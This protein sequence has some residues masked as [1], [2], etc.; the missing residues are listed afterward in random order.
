MSRRTRKITWARA[1]VTGVTLGLLPTAAALAFGNG[2]I[3]DDQIGNGPIGHDEIRLAAAGAPACGP[4][5]EPFNIPLEP[6]P[7]VLKGAPYSAVGTTEVVTT[8]AD[9]NRITR[10]NTMRYFRDNSGR[11]RTE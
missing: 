3:G 2:P 1:G 10:T 8:L 6:Q 9:G 5:V 7:E 11:T 4:N